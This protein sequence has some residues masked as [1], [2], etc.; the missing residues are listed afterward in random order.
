MSCCNPCGSKG[1]MFAGQVLHGHGYPH[2]APTANISHGGKLKPGIYHGCAFKVGDESDESDTCLGRC[3]VWSTPNTV[4][5][6][7]YIAEFD[8]DLYGEVI[9]CRALQRVDRDM[10]RE[11][12]DLFLATM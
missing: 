5:A 6:E 4:I 2:K 3:L 8:G 7:V 9:R 11:G 10:M 1:I 12:Y